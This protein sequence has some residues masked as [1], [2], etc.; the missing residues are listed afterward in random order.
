MNSSASPAGRLLA[1]PSSLGAAAS[2]ASIRES[3]LA[4][5]TAELFH[6][7]GGLSRADL[8][9]RTGLTKATVSRLVRDL[10]EQGIVAEA[11]PEEA[12]TI[13]RPGT[14][15]YPAANTLVGVGLEANA[16]RL[17]GSAVDLSGKVVASFQVSMDL[18]DSSPAETLG[19]LA[20]HTAALFAQLDEVGIRRLV[21]VNLG[22]PG[23]VDQ[24]TQRVVYAPNLGWEDVYPGRY[25]ADLLGGLA[26]TVDNDANL[27]AI[28][29]AGVSLAGQ[30]PV[31]ASFLYLT[32]D[33]GIGGALMR[34]GEVERG[35]HG[36]AGEIGHTSIEPDGPPCHCGSRGCLE[37]YAGRKAIL[38]AAGFPQDASTEDVLSALERGEPKVRAAI[39]R[40]AW[41][42]GIGL[43]NAINLLDIDTVILGTYLAPLTGWVIPGLTEQLDRRII[44]RT[45]ADITLLPAPIQEH[46]TAIGGALQALR[47][48]LGEPGSILAD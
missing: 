40:A 13:G 22:V 11:V 36:W 7:G 24:A 12:G 14:P 33:V 10:I 48:A 9:Q 1:G 38:Q 29:M 6:S 43:A 8:A 16:D 41:A 45:A 30:E 46:P 39:D 27:Q 2:H 32:G 42:L 26:F 15:L 20:E 31:P 47:A 5:V 3:N 4:L 18:V 21:G 25:L 17:L 28:A 19:L 44:G 37:R 23:I 35:P 34:D